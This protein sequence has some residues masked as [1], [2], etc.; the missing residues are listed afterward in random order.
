MNRE[1]VPCGPILSM[2]EAFAD[3]QVEHLR[4]SQPIEHPRLGTISVVGQPVILSRT[5]LGELAP[6]PESGEHNHDVYRSL[7]G[8]DS[9][10][11]EALAAQG[12]I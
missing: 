3:P 8:L 4:M 1:G 12:V 7:L 11:I 10:R 6:A 9:A 2:N 5:S